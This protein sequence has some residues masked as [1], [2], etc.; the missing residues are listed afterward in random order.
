VRGINVIDIMSATSNR[1]HTLTAWAH[2]DGTTITYPA[3]DVIREHD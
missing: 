1:P 3:E 2:V